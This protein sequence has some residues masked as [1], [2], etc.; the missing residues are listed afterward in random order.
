M[1]F[2][3]PRSNRKS[4]HLVFGII[5]L[6]ILTAG[7]ADQQTGKKGKTQKRFTILGLGDSITEGGETFHSYLFPLW[8]KLFSAGYEFDFI[9]PNACKCRIGT[10]NCAGFGGKN[11]EYLDAHI[12]SIY[13]KYPADFVLL[14]TGHNHFN[15]ENPV[16]GIIAA[17]ESIIRKIRV[18]NPN[19]KILVAQVILSGKLPKYSYI[20]DLNKNIAQMVKRL[21]DKNVIVV[22]LAKDFNW[23]EHTIKD[24]VHPN[25]AGAT[26]M[27]EAWYKGL[28]KFLAP[29]GQ[30]FTPDIISFKHLGYE[31]LKL[32]IFKPENFKKG[33]KRAAIIYFFGGGWSVGT[34]LQFYRECAYYASKGM[35]AIAAEYRI[36]YLHKTTP[37]ESVEDAKD[38]IIWLRQNAKQ[39]NLDPQRIAASGSSAGGHLAAATG[40]LH[41]TAIKG[42]GFSS[43]PNLLLLYYPVIDNSEGG[44][45]PAA[46][47]KRY[48]E[49]SPLHNIN[50]E[51]PPTLFVVGTKDPLVP[52]QTAE[53][54][55]K[56]LEHYG[57]LC[58][59]QLFEG[60]G[61][62]IFLYAKPLNDNFYKIRTL[63][64]KFL[65]KYGYVRNY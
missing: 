29:S 22:N 64:D 44:Y 1:Q 23:K 31:D 13:R 35:I 36:S 12:D 8:E 65:Q 5:C 48:K 43:K 59:L 17:Q 30:V 53:L 55:K 27:A 20:P 34:P 14:H 24:Q 19:V 21:N 63:S 25:L 4:V 38:A 58:D 11:A 9:G 45:G 47:K 51:V 39:L 50:A 6:F 33:E 54:F 42:T 62:P 2:N 56:K 7:T 10:L 16:A 15:T 18:I 46:I 61:H 57:I 32:H 41:E 52:V 49:I 3:F 26:R 28:T 40:T 60:S 37:F